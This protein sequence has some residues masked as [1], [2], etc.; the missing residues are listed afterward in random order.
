MFSVAIPHDFLSEAP[1]EASKV[2][3]LGYLARAAAIFK[4]EK[5]VIYHY[6]RPLVE[7][8]D[9]AKTVLDYLVTPPY[10][11]KKVFKLDRRLKLA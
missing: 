1:D 3:K 5:V 6:G 2:R 11:R 4:V 10:L 8:I 7:E 9:L